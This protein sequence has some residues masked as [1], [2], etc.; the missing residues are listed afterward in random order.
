MRAQGLDA[1]RQYGP[2][3]LLPTVRDW[4]ENEKD[5]YPRVEAT[6]AFIAL[7]RKAAAE[8]E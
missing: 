6:R 5:P 1:I 7:S 3:A 8:K 4:I 2:I